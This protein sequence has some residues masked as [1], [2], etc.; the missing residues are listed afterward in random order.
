M[1]NLSLL[2]FFILPVLGWLISR[3]LFRISN[4]V[5]LLP[6]SF[7]LGLSLFIVFIY[8]F[9][10]FLGVRLGGI[11]SLI[12]A[13]ILSIILIIIYKKKCVEV[14]NPLRT[15]QITILFFI[16]LFISLFT[17]LLTD[18]WY[19]LDFHFHLSFA[20][21][22]LASDKFPTVVPNWPTLFIPYHFA[23]DILSATISSLTKISVIDAFRLV[24]SFS[25]ITTFLGAFGLAYYFLEVKNNDQKVQN[26]YIP[27]LMG[28]LCFYFSGNLLWLDAIFRYFLKLFPVEQNWTFFKTICAL[29]MHG[30]IMND[31]ANSE[32][33]FP[34]TIL[35]IQIFLLLIFFFFK[36]VTNDLSRLESFKY[37]F[38]IFLVG[39]CLFHS[40]EYI[41]YLFVLALLLTPLVSLVFKPVNKKKILFLKCLICLIIFV[42][43]ILF[44][45]FAYKILSKPYTFFPTFLEFSL[46]P[47]PFNL[48]VFGRYG[49]LNEHRFINLFSWDFVSEF[50]LQFVFSIFIIFWILKNKIN[51][52]GFVL[53]FFIVSFFSPFLLYIK[54]SPPEV[55]RMFHP[56]YEVLSL[57]FPLWIFGL[58]DKTKFFFNKWIL[59][60]LCFSVFLPPIFT[61]IMSSIFSPAIYLDHPYVEKVERSFK[62]LTENKD[63]NAFTLSINSYL[64]NFKKR[65]YLNETDIKVSE[66]L[67]SNSKLN[68][69]GLSSDSLPFDLIGLPC[70][71][72][73]GSTLSRRMTFYTLLRTLDPFLLD[74]LNVKWFY[75]DSRTARHINLANIED[76]LDNGFLRIVLSV[77][78]SVIKGLNYKL[79]EFVNLK[80]YLK[81]NKRKTYWTI[82]RYLDIDNIITFPDVSGK[83]AIYL[84]QSETQATDFIKDYLITHSDFI[85]TRPFV[86]AL[87]ESALIEQAKKDN[88]N[89]RLF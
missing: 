77:E 52:A 14:Q 46:N 29:G 65:M 25:S 89:L 39:L 16:C 30:S 27:S 12:L 73:R 54:S 57:L 44:N 86:E 4:L 71:A 88:L 22:F 83:N 56:A 78:S 61:L 60:L 53:S 63:F 75:V 21:Y 26:F 87:A 19:I 9:D 66:Y 8:S 74:E 10:P 32:I 37:L 20:N 59:N 24:A 1:A 62:K 81:K 38:L 64:E 36:F 55:V 68:Q 3:N 50:G 84:F 17:Y 28:A 49:N 79:C 33:I 5:Y 82:V 40:A 13:F 80:E 47:N 67:K 69:Y 7:V 23:F 51:G 41:V 34:S 31:V 70:Y 85:K 76:L 35:G 72:I 15:K 43:I 18:R 48:E 45:S 11:V 42:F 6:F 58:K 2:F